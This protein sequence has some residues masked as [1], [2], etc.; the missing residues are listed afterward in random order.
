V[1]R[2]PSPLSSGACY[3]LATFT[4]LPLSKYTVGEVLPLLPS[5]TS[6]FIHSSSGECP[7]PTLQSSGCPALFA[8]CLFFSYLFIIQI[9]FFP[10]FFPGWG[11]V[12]PGGLCWFT[13]CHLAH[14]VI[15]IFQAVWELVSGGAGALLVS[16]FNM[17]WGCYAWAGGVEESEFCF[18]L[19]VFPSRH[20]SSVS[21]RF[22]FRNHAFCFLPLVATLESP[23]CLTFS[24][25]GCF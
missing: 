17:E 2:C 9:G 14:L 25:L 23:P 13:M 20:I 18:F 5:P 11:S 12:C 21:P 10:S 3:A 4:T 8:K 16:P 1:G 6:L 15:C 19:V 7:S 24:T 22:Y